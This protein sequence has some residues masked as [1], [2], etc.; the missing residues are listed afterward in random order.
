M[1][2][3]FGAAAFQQ[4]RPF[5]RTNYA[6]CAGLGRGT[7]PEY[8]RYEGLLTNRSANSLAA[9]SD[10]TSNTLLYGETCGR[11]YDRSVFPIV[12]R[13]ALDLNWFGVGALST[14]RGLG[15]LDP[16]GRPGRG[17]DARAM[18]FSSN[19]P[20]GVLFCFADGSVRLIRQGATFQGPPN[21]STDWL[22]LQQLAGFRDGLTN[23]T[24]SILD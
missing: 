11:S 20:A 8:F 23:N 9:V 17:P 7:H 6:G 19:H 12:P 15:G 5:G 24:S 21:P 18:T 22:L 2:E 4:Y 1:Y 10:G 3:A 13:N 16:D 14:F